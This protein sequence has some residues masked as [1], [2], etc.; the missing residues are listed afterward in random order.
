MVF[1][2][3][4]DQSISSKNSR[5]D[6]FCQS[7]GLTERRYNGNI[8]AVDNPIDYTTVLKKVETHK[9]ASL[10]FLDKALKDFT[11]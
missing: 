7:Y 10:E 4:S 3:Y 1:N 11:K 8:N 2:R 6:S 9:K 5:I